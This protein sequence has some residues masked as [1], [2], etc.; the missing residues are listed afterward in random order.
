MVKDQ[1]Q[2][3]EAIY[4]SLTDSYIFHEDSHEAL[5]VFERSNLRSIRAYNNLY[6]VPISTISNSVTNL[7]H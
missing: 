6:M 3:K 2:A 1:I 7:Q 5:R 4:S